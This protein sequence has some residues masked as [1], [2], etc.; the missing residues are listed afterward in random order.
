M[1]QAQ[2]PPKIALVADWLTNFGGAERVLLSLHH[3]Y[4][5]APIFTTIYHPAALPQFADAKVHTTFLQHFPQAKTKWQRLLPLMPMAIESLDLSAYDLVISSSSCIA[6]GVITK[7]HTLHLAYVHSPMRYAW[8]DYHAYTRSYQ[9]FGKLTKL[10]LPLLMKDIRLWD[11]ITE[12]RVDYFLANSHFIAKRVKKYYRREAEVIY[13]PVFCEQFYHQGQTSDQPSGQQEYFLILCRLVPNKR[14]DLA[15][16]AFNQLGLPLKIAGTGPQLKYLQKLAKPNIEFLGP[17]SEQ[18]KVTLLANC[19]ALIY[20]QVEDFGITALEAAASGRPVIALRAGGAQETVIDGVTGIFFAEQQ[21]EAL[22]AAVRQ[23]KPAQFKPRV[24]V[25]HAQRF[26]HHHFKQHFADTVRRCW[27]EW[28]M[29]M[30]SATIPICQTTA[31]M[32]K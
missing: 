2:P 10:L 31:S 22:I 5:Q 29:K 30:G 3:L 20:P 18:E 24:L 25:E 15:I 26:D 32:S 23:F 13:P 17:V 19:Q 9:K 4:P 28:K 16:E 11:F 6:K 12:K 21:P 1:A 14:V 27:Q 8:D 7:P